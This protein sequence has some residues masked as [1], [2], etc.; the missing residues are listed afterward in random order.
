MSKK[1]IHPKLALAAALILTILTFTVGFFMVTERLYLLDNG[2][3]T[4]GIVV[5]VDVGVRGV[6]SV[7]VEFETHEGHKLTGL[8]IHKTQWKSANKK[9]ENVTLY[10]DPAA[11]EKILI[12]RGIWI[13][14]NPAFLF[15]AGLFIMGLTIALL[16][17]SSKQKL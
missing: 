5:G 17:A 10:Y 8:D 3:Q 14:S 12:M 11:P 2:Q 7:K 4:E 13:W 16:K 15:A 6:R 9:G 1:Q